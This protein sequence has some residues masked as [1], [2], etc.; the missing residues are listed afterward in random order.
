MLKKALV[1]FITLLA[2]A[3]SPSSLDDFKK[4][5]EAVSKSLVVI[6]QKIETREDLTNASPKLKKKFE[7]LVDLMIAARK[8]QILHPEEESFNILEYELPSNEDLITEL[9]RIYSI[10]G[11]REI[12]EDTQR[13]ALLRLDAFEKAQ[14]KN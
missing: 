7:E 9:K 4:E 14:V 3:C 12:I 11:G 2:A 5:G 8:Y 6:L 13:E 10:E 1:I